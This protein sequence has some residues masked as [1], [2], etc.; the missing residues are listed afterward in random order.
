MDFSPATHLIFLSLGEDF[1]TSVDISQNPKISSLSALGN[2][3]TH[4]NAKN[5]KSNLEYSAGPKSMTPSLAYVCCDT[6][7]VQKFS[8]MLAT[9]GHTNVEINSYCS[10]VPGGTTYTVQE[11]QRLTLIIMVVMPLIHINRFRNLTLRMVP[12]QEVI[13]RTAQEIIP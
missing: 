12:T 9:Y 10:F 11:I 8:N 5:G 1:L 6:N 2:S 13:L 4:V 7:K 3:I